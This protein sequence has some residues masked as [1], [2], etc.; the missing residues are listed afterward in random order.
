MHFV[1]FQP[2]FE[3]IAKQLKPGGTFVAFMNIVATLDNPAAQDVMRRIWFEGMYVL[4]RHASD[5]AGRLKTLGRAATGYDVMPV[6]EEFFEN[7]V[8]MSLNTKTWP[9]VIPPELGAEY[10]GKSGMCG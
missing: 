6:P 10:G 4:L 7:V 5:R 1:E 9:E 2:A 8:R 3:A